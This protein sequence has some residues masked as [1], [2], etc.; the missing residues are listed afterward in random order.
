MESDVH[1]KALAAAAR[2]AFSVAFF[3]G[4][5]A[6]DPGSAE[7]GGAEADLRSGCNNAPRHPPRKDA[8]APPALTCEQEVAAAFPGDDEYPG[9]K[10]AVSARVKACCAELLEAKGSPI[11]HRWACCANLEGDAG[12]LVSNACTPWG[13]PV[14]PAMRPHAR[15]P[16]GEVLA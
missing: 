8:A 9:V 11:E 7:Q 5:S 16:I 6:Q 1:S 15:R 14:P 4:C 13:P 12:F 2:V 3:A 10:Q